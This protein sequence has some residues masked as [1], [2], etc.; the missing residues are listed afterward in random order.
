[1]GLGCSVVE[2]GTLLLNARLVCLGSRVH[3]QFR[4][5]VL[6]MRLHRVLGNA[7]RQGNLTSRH[8]RVELR[9]YL[10]FAFRERV[11]TLHAALEKRNALNDTPV[12]SKSPST[13]LA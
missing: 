7:E 2:G 9:E 6:Q 12:L 3:A 1:M 10:A 8:T 11:I 13:S 5:D 4:V